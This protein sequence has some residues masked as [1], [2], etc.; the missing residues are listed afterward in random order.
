MRN[1]TRHDPKITTDYRSYATSSCFGRINYHYIDRYLLEFNGRYDGSS[2]FPK[3]NRWGFFPSVSMGY[4]ISEEPFMKNL[5]DDN[6]PY[7]KL[8]ASYGDLGNQSVGN[9][10]Y[11]QTLA[12]G[13]SS[14]LID[15]KQPTVMTG[16]V[17]SLEVDYV[18]FT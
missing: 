18:I 9:F 12:T 15:V 10:A 3:N 6:V 5:F 17:L 13:N 1:L 2:R 11:I 4:V 7:L 8:R 14:Y 16:C